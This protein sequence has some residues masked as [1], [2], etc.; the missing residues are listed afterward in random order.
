MKKLVLNRIAEVLKEEGR[1]NQWLAAEMK[2]HEN[3]VS[4]WATNRQQPRLSQFYEM[5]ILL[6]CDMRELFV[7]PTPGAKH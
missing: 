7:S 1:T 6:R 3:T 5:S 2:V 4:K